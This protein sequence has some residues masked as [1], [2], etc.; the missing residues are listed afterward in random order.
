MSANVVAY[1]GTG[2]LFWT[3]TEMN[4]GTGGRRASGVTTITFN[5]V[6]SGR[7]QMQGD[8]ELQISGLSE[9]VLITIPI[10]GPPNF[11][12]NTEGRSLEEVDSYISRLWNRTSIAAEILELVGHAG[13]LKCSYNASNFTAAVEWEREKLRERE[14]NEKLFCPSTPDSCDAATNA[15]EAVPGCS[16][17]RGGAE[18]CAHW[19]EECY[20]MRGLLRKIY[21]G[22][23]L[24]CSFWDE[25]AKE[26][27]TDGYLVEQTNDAAT[28]AFTHLTSFSNFIGPP[29][30]TQQHEC[31]SP[32]FKRV[33]YE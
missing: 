19:P 15:E 25:A 26:W 28:C 12:A 11:H 17:V 24:L 2:P 27:R 10:T 6:S 29:P 5:A 31:F 9:P 32:F 3:P 18:D 4:D 7:R 23:Q 20:C 22:H 30:N 16:G 13:A 14:V 8:G 33:D 1:A 21:L